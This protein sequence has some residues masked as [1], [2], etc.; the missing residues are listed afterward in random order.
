MNANFAK[1]HRFFDDSNGVREAAEAV[2]HAD[3]GWF[4][5][6]YVRGTDEIPW[7][8]FLR[9]A[10]L[11][12]DPVT[13]TVADPGFLASRNF[14][15]PMSVASVAPGSEA[16]RAGLRVGDIITEL[17]G[18][19]VG[20]DSRQQLARLAPGD[21]VAVKVRSRRG[22]ERELE[23]KVTGREETSYEVRD[24]ESITPEQRAR[25]AA[26]LKGEAQ[27]AVPGTQSK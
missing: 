16:D 5:T 15:G 21:T 18:K 3:L 12:V 27:S 8:D 14:D 9:S 23:W 22:A 20:E 17:Q 4:F 26:W 24:L 19:P 6:K 10:G 11:R 2:S 13:S 7:N 25:R 1:K